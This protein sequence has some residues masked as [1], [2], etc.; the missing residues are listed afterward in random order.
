MDYLEAKKELGKKY[1]EESKL[2]TSLMELRRS[3]SRLERR[4]EEADKLT[5]DL[6]SRGFTKLSALSHVLT[7]IDLELIQPVFEEYPED[8]D[9]ELEK[10]IAESAAEK[11]KGYPVACKRDKT[12]RFIKHTVNGMKE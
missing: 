5:N 1:E 4:I 3:I 6:M 11:A 10:F 12:G 2:E 9:E 8:Y 7:K